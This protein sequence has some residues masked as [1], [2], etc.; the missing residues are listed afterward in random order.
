MRLLLPAVALVFSASSSAAPQGPS[1][2]DSFT[3]YPYVGAFGDDREC[4]DVRVRHAEETKNIRGQRLG[5]LPPGDL[6]LA[7]DREIDGCRKPVIVRYGIG[8]GAQL[9]A[10][11]HNDSA[12]APIRPPRY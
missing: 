10:Q 1:P 6:I 4:T 3:P 9:E 5:E 7:V 12:P 2:Q 11:P 8:S